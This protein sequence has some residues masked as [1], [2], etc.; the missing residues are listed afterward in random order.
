MWIIPIPLSIGPFLGWGKY[1]YNQ[2]VFFCEQGW[3]VQSGSSR[4]NMIVFP[5]ASFL[6]PFMVIMFLNWAVYKTARRQLDVI[7]IQL[8]SCASSESQQQEIS[9]RKMEHKAAVDVRI[10]IAAF[11][12]CYLPGWMVG[13]LRQFVNR[14]KIPAEAVLVSTGISFL[15]SLCNP[16]IYSI[17]KREF[18]KAVKNVLRR[19]GICEDNAVFDVILM[20]NSV[21]S[22][23]LKPALATRNQDGKLCRNVGSIRMNFATRLSPIPEI[24]QTN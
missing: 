24:A 10:I 3:A 14:F 4:W 11:L 2:E 12:L 23:N 1:V 19:M 8:G 17:R 7:N 16:V 18:R 13:V 6:V 20:N 9:Q 21:L 5:I 15:S 22:S